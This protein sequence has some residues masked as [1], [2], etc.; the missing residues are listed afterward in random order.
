MDD[1]LDKLETFLIKHNITATQFGWSCKRNPN[2]VFRLRKGQMT[3]ST[4]NDVLTFIEENPK[5]VIELKKTAKKAVAKKTVKKPVAR[6]PVAKL[7]RVNAK[8]KK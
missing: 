1:I 6:K 4:V 5:G 3:L 2:L 7:V 8:K